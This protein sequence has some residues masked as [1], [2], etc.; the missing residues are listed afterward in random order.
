[1][2]Q[3][4]LSSH[5][6]QRRSARVENSG[7]PDDGVQLQQRKRSARVI[8]VDLALLQA[9]DQGIRKRIDVDLQANC[10]GRFGAYARSHPSVA[11]SLNCLVQLDG[12]APKSLITESIVAEDP[13]ASV[14]RELRTLV[15]RPLE[16]RVSRL[17]ARVRVRPGGP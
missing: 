11:A 2:A 7:H 3:R 13:P 6:A 12:I 5:S 14:H 9:L 4:A 10:E 16:L 1:M 15:R 17:I 8:E